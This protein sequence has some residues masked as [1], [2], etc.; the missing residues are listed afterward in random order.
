MLRGFIVWFDSYVS[1]AGVVGLIEGGLGVIAFGGALSVVFGDSAPKAAAVVAILLALMGVLLLLAAS[2][3]EWRRRGELS[4]R[5]LIEHCRA[6]LQDNQSSWRLMRWIEHHRIDDNGDTVVLVTVH[7]VV[8]CDRLRFYRL[9]MGSGQN[10]PMKIRGQVHVQAR[11]VAVGGVGGTGHEVT[12]HWADDA[13]MEVLVHFPVP[14]YCGSE[15]SL[16]IEMRW[17]ARSKRLVRDRLPDDFCVRIR[18]PLNLLEY[19]VALPAGEEAF[20]DPIG[21][22]MDDSHFV[23]VSRSNSSGCQEISLV[24]RDVP[25]D[26]RLGMRV[27]LK[28]KELS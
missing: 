24:G 13:R 1:R 27:D 22:G 26:G 21:F 23:L 18:S 8:T 2:R 12:K 6:F 7:A 19:T 16:L 5:L 15:F 28:R 25:I 14:V 11:S 20:Y 17:P 3:A 9:R 10:Q 4:E